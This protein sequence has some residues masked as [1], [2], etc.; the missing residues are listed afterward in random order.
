VLSFGGIFL[1][2]FA[3]EI[4]QILAPGYNSAY[5]AVGLLLL[6]II[7]FGMS[8]LTMAGISYTRR[9]GFFAVG[10]ALALVTHVGLN[11]ALMPSIGMLGA[12][13]STLAAYVLLASGYLFISQRL[14]PTRYE[15]RKVFVTLALAI[16]LGALGVVPLG[17]PASELTLKLLAILVFFVGIRILHVVGPEETREIRN[18]LG[19]LFRRP[20]AQARA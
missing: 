9:S 13:I 8:G 2:L 4:V 17:P 12:A 1:A 14:Y 5:E 20:A 15:G 11:F 3:Q 16:P 7:F 18:L 10:A 19:G 6:A